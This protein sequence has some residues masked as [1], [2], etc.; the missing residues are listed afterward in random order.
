MSQ[1][2]GV[3]CYF[4]DFAVEISMV[5]GQTGQYVYKCQKFLIPCDTVEKTEPWSTLMNHA[6]C[7]EWMMI[8]KSLDGAYEIEKCSRM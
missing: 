7:H 8:L 2:I 6:T 4:V 5:S 1:I 3:H